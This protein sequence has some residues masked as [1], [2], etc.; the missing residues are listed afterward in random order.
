MNNTII[1]NTSETV[2][3]EKCVVCSKQT[4]VPINKHIDYRN[5]YVEG[6]GQL[7]ECCYINLDNRK[8]I[9]L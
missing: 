1:K 9:K 7:C 6:A 4:D 8:Y 3:F 5:Y 2:P